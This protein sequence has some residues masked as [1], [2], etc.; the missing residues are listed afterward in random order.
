MASANYAGGCA[1]QDA[2]A[3][4]RIA[5]GQMA[6]SLDIGWM[7]NIGIIAESGAYQRQRQTFN[8]MQPIDDNE[9]FA[10]LTF[11]CD[12]DSPA[13]VPPMAQVQALSGLR[14]PADILMYGQSHPNLLER[15]LLAAF[16]YL[17]HAENTSDHEVNHLQDAKALCHG[18]K[19]PGERA[20]IDMRALASSSPVA[21]WRLLAR[22]RSR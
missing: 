16:S 18:T 11:C 2:V 20:S 22:G 8:N 15:P 13:L 12:P 1:Y 21:W 4:Y 14:T 19:D 3:A 10:L 6:L 9:L 7:R 5:R 17:V